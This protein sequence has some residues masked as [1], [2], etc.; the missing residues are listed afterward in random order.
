MAAKKTDTKTTAAKPR[1]RTAASG[2][3]KTSS[4]VTK[5]GNGAT[6]GTSPNGSGGNRSDPKAKA[7][8]SGRAAKVFSRSERRA[9][10]ALKD[11]NEAAKLDKEAT[12]KAKLHQVDLGDTFED[13]QT[14]LR[15]TR[16]YAKGDYRELPMG[17]MVAAV[18]AVVYFVSPIDAIPD[19]LPGVGFIDDAAVLL[20]VVKAISK[21][22]DDFRAWEQV[23]AKTNRRTT[24]RRAPSTNAGART[25]L[26]ASAR[27]K[28]PAATRKTSAKAAAS[29]TS[30]KPAPR[31]RAAAK[32]AA[33][34]PAKPGAKPAGR[35]PAAKKATT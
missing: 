30:A 10:T 9:R 34:K 31:E 20:F 11:T 6:R 16:S 12:K 1:R 35:Q 26:K 24:T 7:G 8:L 32:P 25:G 23:N 33:R 5:A 19:A 3:R 28:K 18:A 13:L 17:T 4:R 21:D 14:L 15:L 2:T 22:L 29:K 27:A